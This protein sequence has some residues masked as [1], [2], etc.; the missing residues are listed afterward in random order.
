MKWWED[1][2]DEIFIGFF[3][4]IIACAAIWKGG[5]AG[6]TAAGGAIGALGVYLGGKPGRKNG[7]NNAP[8]TT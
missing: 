8:P 4:A 7:G 3:I 5:V 6:M 1:N 2:V